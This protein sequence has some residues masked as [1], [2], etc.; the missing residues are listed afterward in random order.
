MT[1]MGK[2][3]TPAYKNN[4]CDWVGDISPGPLQKKNPYIIVGI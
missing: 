1:A 3:F 4:I 2:K